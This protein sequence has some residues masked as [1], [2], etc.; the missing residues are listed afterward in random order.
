MCIRDR[1]WDWFER[2]RDHPQFPLEPRWLRDCE[3]VRE[4]QFLVPGISRSVWTVAERDAWLKE[5]QYLEWTWRKCH[6]SHPLM[7]PKELV[8]IHD[9]QVREFVERMERLNVE[10]DTW[11]QFQASK[12]S[13]ARYL[14]ELFAHR[15]THHERVSDVL[16]GPT[17]M[18]CNFWN[19]VDGKAA[20]LSL[21]HISE[22]TRP[23]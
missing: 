4:S 18:V 21:I 6:S 2:M 16:E 12:T 1:Y 8:D 5:P 7:V 9:V 15:K 23:Y 14:R 17:S 10:M 22:P 13:A 11:V 3:I 19:Y 20:T